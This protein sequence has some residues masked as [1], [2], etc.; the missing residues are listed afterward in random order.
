MKIQHDRLKPL[1][2]LNT[3]FEQWFDTED[4]RYD[5]DAE[6][7]EVIHSLLVEPDRLSIDF[8]SAPVTALSELLN[9]LEQ[10]G[11]K[12]ICVSS[13]QREAEHA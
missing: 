13:S 2:G 8:G 11:A 12:N 6:L 5:K 1:S 7:C 4:K 3:W 9:L 10:E